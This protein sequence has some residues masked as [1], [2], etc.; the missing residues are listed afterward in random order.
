M[1][2]A[3]RADL[4]YSI[5]TQKRAQQVLLLIHLEHQSQHDYTMAIR[6][7]EYQT[8]IGRAW[9][10]QRKDKRVPP[11]LTFVVYHGAEE[12]TSAKSIAELFTDFEL[13]MFAFQTPFLID[14]SKLNKEELQ[15]HGK[16][17]APVMILS[18]QPK[19]SMHDIINFNNLP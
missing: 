17:N 7:L 1:K 14:L 9:I 2:K 12:W 6:I 8:A 19:E 15:R 3:F 18:Q 13:Q 10:K 5:K 16:A 4:L 11:I